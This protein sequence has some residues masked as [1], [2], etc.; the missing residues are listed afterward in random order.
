[1]FLH[2]KIVVV[3]VLERQIGCRRS[4]TWVESSVLVRENFVNVVEIQLPVD[5]SN[6]APT[7]LRTIL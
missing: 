4:S 2:S 3:N 1:M 7:I 6:I 5:T